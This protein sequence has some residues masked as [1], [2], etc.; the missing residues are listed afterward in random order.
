MTHILNITRDDPK[1]HLKAYGGVQITGVDR[2]EVQCEINAPQLATLVEEDGDVYVTVNSSC[3][4]TVPESSSISIERGMGSIA[5]KNIKNEINIEKAMGNLVVQDV[6][7][8]IVEKIGGNFAARN[9][10]G[11]INVE[12]IGGNL[13]LENI[14]TFSGDKTGGSCFIKDLH[15]DFILEK[16]GGGLRGQDIEGKTMIERV[17]GSFIARSLT[18][19]KDLHVGGSIHLKDV[20]FEKMDLSMKAGGS[21]ELAIGQAFTGAKFFMKSGARDIEIKFNDDDFEIEDQSYEYST[22]ELDQEI[23]LSAGSDVLITNV[24]DPDEEVV[25]DLSNYFTFEETPF[26]EMIQE[27]IESATRIAEAKVRAAEIRL[28]NIQEHMDKVREIR[29]DKIKE[30]MDKV[31]DIHMKVNLDDIDMHI[32]PVPPVSTIVKP[33]GKKGA[34]DEERLMILKMLQEKKITVDEAE[35]LFQALED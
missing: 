8:V 23:T 15:G 14:G 1:I 34:S 25:C 22:G 30:D 33:I 4:L 19:A 20:D 16:A 27:R 17:G 10:L 13:V 11:D 18:L 26:S 29:F 28:E 9:A 32:P 24:Q 7:N 5:I 31:K 3:S 12:K 2:T 21:V 6:A 35:S